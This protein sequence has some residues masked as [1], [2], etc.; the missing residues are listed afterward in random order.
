MPRIKTRPG[1][2]FHKRKPLWSGFAIRSVY[3]ISNV[4]RAPR[5]P[6]ASSESSS[7]LVSTGA[8]IHLE[9][10]I[11]AAPCGQPLTGP[12]HKQGPRHFSRQL[13]GRGRLTQEIGRAAGRERE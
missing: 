10:A 5:Q 8:R 9:H 7:G 12:H 4:V 11:A 13:G 6:L 1:G 2:A 3:V